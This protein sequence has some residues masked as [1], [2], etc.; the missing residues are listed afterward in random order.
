MSLANMNARLESIASE[1]RAGTEKPAQQFNQGHKWYY[2]PQSPQGDKANFE[3]CSSCGEPGHYRR[4]CPK[5]RALVIRQ[6]AG[7]Q[8]GPPGAAHRAGTVKAQTAGYAKAHG[9]CKNDDQN[10]RRWPM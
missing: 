2:Q 4:N 10:K 1:K 8:N 5:E 9:A 3:N 6:E 7:A